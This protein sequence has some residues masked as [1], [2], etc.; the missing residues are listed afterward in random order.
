MHEQPRPVARAC[1]PQAPERDAAVTEGETGRYTGRV[2]FFE[3]GAGRAFRNA[4]GTIAGRA[5]EAV[6]ASC[7]PTPPAGNFP[8][9]PRAHLC[10][11]LK[12]TMPVLRGRKAGVA[13]TEAESTRAPIANPRTS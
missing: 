1:G 5:R 2:V 12:R 8:V 3:G 13:L 6:R 4:S 7:F 10:V 9:V 11:R